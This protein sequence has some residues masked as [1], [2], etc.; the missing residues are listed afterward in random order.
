MVEKIKTLHTWRN[1]E[2]H[3]FVISVDGGINAQTASIAVQAGAD[4]VAAGSYCL[5]GES[6]SA[7]QSNIESLR[8]NLPQ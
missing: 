5:K 2:D 4:I 7:Y 3:S 6:T 1:H 8:F